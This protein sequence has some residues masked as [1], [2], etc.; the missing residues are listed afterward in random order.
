MPRYIAFLRA[1]NVGGRVTPMARLRS[2]FEAMEF[3][4]VSTYIASG[5]VLF[6]STKKEP[7]LVRAIESTLAKK[8]GYEV[9]PF[10][11]TEE[12]VIALA[13]GPAL[14]KARGFVP[15]VVVGFCA[16]PPDAAARR[17]IAAIP[18]PVDRFLVDGRHILWLC[19][20][21]QSESKVTLA[22]LEKALEGR[23]T[24]RG[25]NTIDKLAAKLAAKSGAAAG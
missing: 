6:A 5:N 7:T 15:T 8:L 4:D 21:K 1:I 19:D 14:A 11:R 9:N 22:T 23:A 25:V 3:D 16:A 17:R 24:F 10:L 18:S 12:E 13:A 20:V 2:I